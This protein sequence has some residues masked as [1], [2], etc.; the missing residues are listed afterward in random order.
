[1]KRLIRLLPAAAAFLLLAS[2]GAWA[3]RA[4]TVSDP[5]KTDAQPRPTATPAVPVP[6]TVK[7]KYEGGIF[8]FNKKQTGTLNFDDTNSRLVFRDK[9]G[10]EYISLP[11]ETI[12]AAYGDTRS[13]RPTAATVIG[14]VPSIY[15]LPALF[16][17]SKY[18]YLTLQFNDKDTHVQ[19]TTSFKLDSKELLETMVAAVAQKAELERRGEAYVRKPKVADNTP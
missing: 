4:R 2:A 5:A 10:H 17:R 6:Q 12:A 16:V 1:M 19:G 11:Y 3:Q 13:R 18:R 15:A 9:Q 8:G 14:S 7:A